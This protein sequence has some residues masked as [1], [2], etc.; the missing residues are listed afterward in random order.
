MSKENSGIRRGPGGHGSRM[1][2]GEK[3]KDF[4]GTMKKLLKE[5]NAFKIGLIAVLIAAIASAAFS[6]VGPKILGKVTTKIFEGIVDK[7]SGTG[8]GID[9]DAIGKILLFLIGLYIVSALFQLMQS[10]IMSGVSQK[11]CYNLRTELISKVN[12]MPMNYFESRTN[13][14]ILSRFTNDIDT[15]GQSLNQSV[16]QLITS[17]TTVIGILIM[18]L[19]ISVQM[20]LVA[21][22]VLPVSGVLI[23]MVVKR[24]QKY[25]K[26]QQE[27]LGHVNG[28]VEE[29]YGGHN[30]VKVFN[31][32]KKSIEEFDKMNGKLYE[33]AWKSQFLSGLMMPIIT[34]VGNLGYV[35]V[36]IMGG[37]LAIK[38]TIEVGDI[39]SFIQYVK[40]FTQPIA[41]LAQVSNMIQSTVAAAERVFEFLD[42]EEEDQT[43]PNPV[44]LEGLK[45]SVQFENVHFG[46]N[47]DKIIINDFSVNVKPG[48]KVA[49]VGPTGAGKTTMVKLLMRFYDVNSGSIK[50]DGHNI[51]DFNRTE[52]RDMFGMVLQETWLFN[53]SIKENIRY[54][55]LDASDEEVIKAAKAAHVD[56]FIRTLPGG[57]DMELNEEASN[58][59][60]GQKQLLT[61]ARAILADPKILILDEATSSVDTRT[62]VL[63]QKAMDNLMEGR[64][65]FIIA[66]RLS[67]IRDADVIL[68]MKDGD[69][70]EQG[71][72]EELLVAKGF[73]YNLYNSQFEK[74]AVS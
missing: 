33:S 25:F 65:S 22:L 69:I 64:T 74:E 68:V 41:Q 24:S 2:P 12:R 44:K 56:H 35:G 31:R 21:L 48:Q 51:K 47:P 52:L 73:Y 60:Q 9:F 26:S 67:T 37:W 45:G 27:Y 50:I 39:Q 29:V 32:E 17:V 13:G 43:V 30:I 7:I 66:H 8:T 38:K 34:F 4:K 1:A 14:E 11:M 55:Q 28:Q 5:L 57:Y 72:H 19:S 18:M 61:I 70:I 15:L 23:G 62:E 59:S 46:Y 3:A 10:Y 53:G 54:G 49:I 16:T 58:V 42:E 20:T 6:I 40:N 36:S 63:I 71:N